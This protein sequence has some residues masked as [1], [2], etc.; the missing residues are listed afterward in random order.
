MNEIEIEIEIWKISPEYPI[1]SV[2]NYGNVKKNNDLIFGWVNKY[3]KKV[4][5]INYN[6]TKK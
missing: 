3:G 4:I 6:N 5:K 1:Y 2:S